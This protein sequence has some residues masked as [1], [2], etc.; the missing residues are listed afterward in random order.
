MGRVENL[1]EKIDFVVARRWSEDNLRGTAACRP[2]LDH[3]SFATARRKVV[4]PGVQCLVKET[5]R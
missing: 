3:N 5:V 1:A 4:A 2:A